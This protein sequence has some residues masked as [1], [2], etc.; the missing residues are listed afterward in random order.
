MIEVTKGDVIQFID[1]YKTDGTFNHIKDI[2]K[3]STLEYIWSV[4]NI[5]FLFDRTTSYTLVEWQYNDC[6][7]SSKV[8]MVRNGVDLIDLEPDLTTWI[9][10]KKIKIITNETH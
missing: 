7:L 3:R 1:S 8:N 9:R 6:F 4:L 10:N 5:Y 2:H